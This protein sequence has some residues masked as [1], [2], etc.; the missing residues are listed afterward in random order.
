MAD[1]LESELGEGKTIKEY[2]QSL[3]DKN[4]KLVDTA[5]LSLF[6]ELSQPTSTKKEITKED[7]DKLPPCIG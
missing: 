1:Y 7:T 6:K 5:Q 3:L 4:V 2:A